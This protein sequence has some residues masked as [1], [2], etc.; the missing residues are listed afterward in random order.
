MKTEHILGLGAG[1]ITIGLLAVACSVRAPA[2][3][4][5]YAP[6]PAPV[7][8]APAPAGY[9]PNPVQYDQAPQYAAAPAPAPAP[10]PAA[11]P[12]SSGVGSFV[13]GAA[14]GALAGH[15]LTKKADTA[16]APTLRQPSRYVP[17][18]PPTTIRRPVLAPR[19]AY[20]P[21]KRPSAPAAAPMT[22]KRVTLSKRK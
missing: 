1:A 3:E 6:T 11:A 22:Y 19:Q 17:P 15:L 8:A 5:R 12:Q 14:A 18:A 10:A 16:P 7:A 21:I 4:V 13:A 20:T 9:A 2:P